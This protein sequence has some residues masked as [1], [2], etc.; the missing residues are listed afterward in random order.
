[1]NGAA[2]PGGGIKIG[3]V[4]HAGE[5]PPARQRGVRKPGGLR[6]ALHQ[7]TNYFVAHG[8]SLWEAKQ[9]AIQW[10]GQQVQAQSSYLGYMDAFL[11][12]ILISLTAVPLALTFRKV[13][14]C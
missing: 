14:A 9:Q 12:L 1:M 7:A 11:V 13:K 2:F 8:S 4:F 3:D 10:V 5:N 6:I